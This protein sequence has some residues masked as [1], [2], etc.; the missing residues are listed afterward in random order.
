MLIQICS[1]IGFDMLTDKIK[2]VGVTYRDGIDYFRDAHHIVC[3]E[4]CRLFY[5]FL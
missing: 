1:Q 4:S 5:Q 3:K 2:Y